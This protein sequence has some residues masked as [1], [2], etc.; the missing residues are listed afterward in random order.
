MNE[1]IREDD[2]QTFEGWLTYHALEG[3]MMTREELAIW[4]GRFE[5]NRKER[6]SSKVGL[7]NLKTV[8][9]EH[10]YAVAVREG[11][12]LLLVLWIRRNRK[13][14][15]VVLK[16]MDERPLDRQ[17]RNHRDVS[18]YH[19]IVRQKVVPAQTSQSFPIM[20]GFTPTDTGAICD[21]IAFT[22]IVEVASGI[23]GPRH[24]SVGVV[25]A[26]PGCG[27]PDYTWAY[28]VFTQTVF[29]DVSPHVVVSVMRKK[30]S[31]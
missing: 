18:L 14:E 27:L 28:D 22:G 29:R 31:G 17:S 10:K 16:P 12:D 20:N 3:S 13:G 23:L 1:C 15:Y 24:G 8:P 5:E 9:G 25:L 21:P 26:E 6:A 19:K 7:M 30:H 11:T 2:L 4:Q